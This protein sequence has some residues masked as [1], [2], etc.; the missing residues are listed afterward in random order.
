MEVYAAMVDAMDYH[1]GRVIDYLKEIGEYN[2]TVIIFLSDNGAN[3]WYSN[4][5]PG[6]ETEEFR[7]QFDESFENIGKKGSNYA[8]GT[9]FASGSSGPLT[10]FKMTV[11]EGG[12]RVPFLIAGPGIDSGRQSDAFAYVWDIMPTILEIAGAEYPAE[13]NGQP[14]EQLRGRSFLGLLNGDADSIYSED[15]FI[16]GEMNGGRWMR[17]GNYKATMIPRPYGE[18]IWQLFDVE[19]DPGETKDLSTDMPEKLAVL[20]AAWDEYANDV[21]VIPPE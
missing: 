1:Y 17:Q 7:S 3:P 10:R 9:G 11:G 15:D 14:V 19:T 8:Y 13:F 18:G 2:N 21:G 12:I 6:A 5:Y 16:G 4:Q 20:H